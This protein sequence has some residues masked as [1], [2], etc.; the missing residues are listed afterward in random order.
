MVRWLAERVGPTGHVTAADIDPRYFGD[1]RLPN[2]E[3]R[4]CNITL[5]D[6]EPES[7]DLV[8][9]RFVLMHLDEP[10][11]ALQRM[12]GALRSGGWLVAADPDNDVAGS[13][14]PD[15]PLSHLRGVR[16]HQRCTPPEHQT[17]AYRDHNFSRHLARPAASQGTK[18]R[19]AGT[20]DRAVSTGP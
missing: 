2:V 4:Q 6:V 7:Y 12:T 18:S 10:A 17:G 5:D 1:L 13:V 9:C 14:D 8:H 3:V 11:D 19:S 15:H 16:Q 20:S